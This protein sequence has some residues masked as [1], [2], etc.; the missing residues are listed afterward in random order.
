MNVYTIETFFVFFSKE[1]QTTQFEPPGSY[2]LCWKKY[3]FYSKYTGVKSKYDDRSIA[4]P[5]PNNNRGNKTS[6]MR[7][8]KRKTL[9]QINNN[10]KKTVFFSAYFFEYMRARQMKWIAPTNRGEK[11]AKFIW[12]TKAAA[13]TTR[14]TFARVYFTIFAIAHMGKGIG[15]FFTR[16]LCLHN[17]RMCARVYQILC[18]RKKDRTRKTQICLCK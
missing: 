1:N 3:S 5:P 2:R 15:L 12:S 17:K 6:K 11:I 9:F 10:N 16:I 14:A 8:T 4:A 7:T 18:G 13:T